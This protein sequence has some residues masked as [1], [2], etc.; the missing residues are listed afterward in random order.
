MKY[1][2]LIIF[3]FLLFGCNVFK[4]ASNKE[5]KNFDIYLLIGQ[6]N[7]AGRAEIPE[8]GKDSLNMVFLFR[9][10]SV[11]I[12]E[13]AANPLNKYS[14]VRKGIKMQKLGARLLFCEEN[15]RLLS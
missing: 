10:D 5:F 13:K 14:T 12:W 15:F 3:Q 7:M 2:F 11:R 6:S 9:N 8:D 1:I 4:E